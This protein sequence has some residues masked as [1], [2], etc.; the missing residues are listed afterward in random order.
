LQSS[1]VGRIVIETH[2]QILKPTGRSQNRQTTSRTLPPRLIQFPPQTQS[3]KANRS[4][5]QKGKG[6]PQM[7]RRAQQSQRIED[8]RAAATRR[9]S[10][11]KERTDHI[12]AE[13]IVGVQEQATRDIVSQKFAS[14]PQ[15]QTHGKEVCHTRNRKRTRQKC[16]KQAT[17]A[18][19]VQELPGTRQ[20][21]LIQNRKTQH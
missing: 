10:E 6:N 3:I 9:L 16:E 18:T 21:R 8:S 15:I 19:Q 5:R 13:E 12:A 2:P 14:H 17:Q 11:A 20:L 4:L 1:I 7:H